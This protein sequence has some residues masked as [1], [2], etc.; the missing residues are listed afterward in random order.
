MLLLLWRWQ[1]M[2][3]FKDRLAFA[4]NRAGLKQAD[5]V[6]RTGITKSAL[7]SYLSGKYLAKQDN[8][9]RLALVLD[10]NEAWLMGLD[11]P[12]E[13]NLRVAD[14]SQFAKQAATLTGKILASKDEEKIKVT[15]NI[16]E[17]IALM[18]HKQ[19]EALEVLLSTIK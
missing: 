4:I 9:Y 2:A 18:N 12:M 11:V 6:A 15:L 10:V 13:R 16:L 5:V 1:N 14:A 8:T 7:S 3:E 17:K 19:L